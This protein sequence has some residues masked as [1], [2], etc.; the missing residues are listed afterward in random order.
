MVAAPSH[1]APTAPVAATAKVTPAKP[2]KPRSSASAA[3]ASTPKPPAAAPAAAAA[4]IKPA[5][6]PLD[7]A[8][9][10]QRLKDT[11]AI[12]VF[13]KLSLKNQVDDLLVDFKKY[14][15]AGGGPPP[16]SAL[17]SQYELL[18]IKVLS[19]LQDADPQLASAISSS[20][21]ALWDILKDPNKFAKI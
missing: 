15:Q 19:L 4:P 20:R 17:R 13:T 11:K 3:P 9:L 14:H 16:P 1:A 10:E 8:A 7:L 12:G 18:I 21:E 5:Q 2:A 6:P